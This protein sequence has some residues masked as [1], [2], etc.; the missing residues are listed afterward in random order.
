ML[1]LF[2]L[3]L[4]AVVRVL[5]VALR[6]RSDLLLENIA[7][8]QQVGVLKQKQPR[9]QLHEADRAFWVAMRMAWRGWATRLVLVEPDTVVRWHRERFRRYWTKLSR[10]NR[11]PGSGVRGGV[12]L[13]LDISPR[14]I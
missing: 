6:S 2:L 3:L 11:G 8:R 7:L 9:P 1:R 12:D 5:R 4:T 14:I 13:M 10:H